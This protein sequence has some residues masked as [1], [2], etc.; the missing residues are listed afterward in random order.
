MK[1]IGRKK[2]INRYTDMASAEPENKALFGVKGLGKSTIIQTVFSKANC[3]TY[4]DEYHCLYVRTILDSKIK[5]DGLVDF[6]FDRVLNGIDL[7]SDDSVVEGIRSRIEIAKER[8]QSKDSLLR[9]TLDTIHDYEY[10]FVLVMDDFHNMGRS[11]DVGS[12]QYDFLRSLNEQ[13]LLYYWIISDSDFSDVYA[14]SQ[15][16]TS[17]FAQKFIPTTINQMNK[18]DIF[19]LI[20]TKI[21]QCDLTYNDEIAE[22]IYSIIGGIPALV[23]PAVKC[24]EYMEKDDFETDELID[25]MLVNP[26]CESLMTVWSRSLTEEQKKLLHKISTDNRL[27]ESECR[28]IIGDIN[29][30]G[31]H[32]GLGLLIHDTDSSGKYWRI[33][34]LI[35]SEY[36]LRKTDSFY[37]AGIKTQDTNS[38]STPP[39]TTTYIQN[40]Y[41]NINNNFFNPDAALEALV[42]LK[43]LIGS[44]IQPMALPEDGI[45]NNAIK[46]LPYQQ[47]EW[48]SL[49]DTQ[50]DEKMGEYADKIFES[51]DFSSDALSDN[52][53][54]RF[55]LSKELLESIPIGSRNNLVSAIQVYDLLQFCVDKFGLDMSNSESAR[56]ILFARAYES[57]LKECLRPALCSIEDVSNKTVRNERSE[58]IPFIDATVDKITIG[59]FVYM[60]QDRKVQRDLSDVCNELGISEY[61]NKWWSSHQTDLYN[62]SQLRN[63]CCHSGH[64]FDNAK[65]ELLIKYLFELQNVE[66]VLIYNMIANRG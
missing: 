45:I 28:D 5:G 58:W 55:Y 22:K 8:Y 44:G 29:Q 64:H 15:F 43:S 62:I 52:Q 63:D 17:F 66:K 6:L 53:M 14:T 42:S 23:E 20:H 56:G 33:N 9:D 50:K 7:I 35:Y 31:D 60:L 54:K 2:E 10:S 37:S 57:I 26:K 38:E 16:T 39:S 30:L 46:Q 4:A 40:N 13:G 12:E 49:D 18:D 41:Y 3:K 24:I 59:T 34:S 36:I 19:E 11:S 1:I 51:G 61:D 65:L 27:Y 47:S 21:S 25:L 32:S 48:D